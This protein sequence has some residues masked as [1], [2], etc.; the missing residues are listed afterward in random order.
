L[1]RYGV[2]G[3]VV[4]L[5]DPH[6]LT[7]KAGGL[8]AGDPIEGRNGVTLYCTL[9]S[10]WGTGSVLVNPVQRPKAT[11]EVPRRMCSKKH[12][13]ATWTVLHV[14][15]SGWHHCDGQRGSDTRH[16]LGLSIYSP[17]TSGLGAL[18]PTLSSV[19]GNWVPVT[20]RVAHTS[21]CVCR[22][23]EYSLPSGGSPWIGES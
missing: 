2:G 21:L 11:E 5:V 15:H 16:D 10:A 22:V 20:G 13:L 4:Q 9:H 3:V 8:W 1:C 23:R 6:Y 17:P 12:T 7:L 19:G 18:F 14:H